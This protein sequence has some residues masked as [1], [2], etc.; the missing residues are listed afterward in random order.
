MSPIDRV[1]ISGGTLMNG[2]RNRMG[3]ARRIGNIA[4]RIGREFE[5]FLRQ[6]I[7]I[8]KAGFFPCRRSHP[9][10]LRHTFRRTLDKGFFHRNGLGH[11]G[12]KVEIGIV[13][14]ANLDPTERPKH[15]AFGQTK[16]LQLNKITHGVQILMTVGI[17][18]DGEV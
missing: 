6:L 11:T 14:I 3:P 12:L 17:R 16:G 4:C 1:E 5:I 10:T 7:G 18:I 13:D 15:L 2:N 8:G 9:H